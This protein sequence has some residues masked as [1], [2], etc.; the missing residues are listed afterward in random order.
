LFQGGSCARGSQGKHHKK[1]VP[2]FPCPLSSSC[3]IISIFALLGIR[4]RSKKRKKRCLRNTSQEEDRRGETGEG[5][6]V[7]MERRGRRHGLGMAG[8][9]QAFLSWDPPPSPSSVLP[10]S[11][12]LVLGGRGTTRDSGLLKASGRRLEE[13]PIPHPTHAPSR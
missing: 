9:R 2:L 8:R 12:L 3:E 4:L 6:G 13:K 5:A 1:S 10:P 7:G 11:S